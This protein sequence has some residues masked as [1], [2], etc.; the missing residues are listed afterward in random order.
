MNLKLESIYL[1]I[2]KKAENIVF[3]Q[4]LFLK[5]FLIL[6]LF[7]LS[8]FPY[9]LQAQESKKVRD[10]LRTLEI[11]KGA[12][13][14]AVK[15][16]ASAESAEL[17]MEIDGLIMDETI[18]KVGRDF[19]DMF[20]SGWNA[21]KN[22]KNFTI[23]IKEMVLPG[24]ATQVTVMVNDNEVFKQRVQPRYDILEQMSNYAIQQTGRYLSNYEKMKSQLDGDDQSGS[25]IF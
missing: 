21:P 6:V 25:G 9:S 11:L 16:N 18:S 3:K 24:L 17:D 23:T 2:V 10:S 20:Y 22:A 12:L 19:Y 15:N 14:N 1:Y 7:V 13:N 8:L 5:R 4:S